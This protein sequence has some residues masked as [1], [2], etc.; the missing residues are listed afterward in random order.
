MLRANAIAEVDLW[1]LLDNS[2]SRLGSIRSLHVK[3]LHPSVMALDLLLESSLSLVARWWH[4][5]WGSIDSVFGTEV[6]LS[7]LVLHV[8]HLTVFSCIW[9]HWPSNAWTQ[10][11]A[12]VE[13]VLDY[14]SSVG[15][16]VSD[17]RV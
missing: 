13:A 8:R 17:N 1:S 10:L 9:H 2:S 16:L 14:S 6:S 3:G 4:I 11:L 15:L 12:D 7:K 5:V